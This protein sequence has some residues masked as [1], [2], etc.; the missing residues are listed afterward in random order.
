MKR[1]DKQYYNKVIEPLKLVTINNLFARSVVEQKV[2]G[3]IFVD[4]IK[5]PK[6]FYVIHPYGMSLLFGNFDN[7]TFNSEFKEYVLNTNHNR[8]GD[9]WMQVFPTDWEQV[10]K[11]LFNDIPSNIVEFNTRTNFNLNIDKYFDTKSMREKADPLVRIA[12]TDKE[13]CESIKGTVIPLKFW[14]GSADFVENGVGFSSFYNGE[15]ASTAFSAFI[16]DNKLELGIETSEEF[17]GKGLA[18]K[19][20]SALIDYCIE[21]KLEPLW[22][23]RSDNTGSYKL[24]ETLGFE[25]SIETAYYKLG[26]K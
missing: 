22:A 14:N 16:H 19:T 11:D 24:A 3:E 15:L 12:R 23:C 4:N 8:K 18:Y 20:C 2:E 17:K 9:E 26:V 25:K 21:N 13:T 7:E 1:L 6:T 10:L 5:D